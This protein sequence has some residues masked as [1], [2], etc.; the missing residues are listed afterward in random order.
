MKKLLTIICALSL[1]MAF[2]VPAMAIDDIEDNNAGC[3]FVS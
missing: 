3:S 2:T 1:I